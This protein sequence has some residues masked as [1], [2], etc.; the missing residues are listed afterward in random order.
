MTI[1]R[2]GQTIGPVERL[3]HFKRSTALGGLGAAE[4][5]VI[6]EHARERRFRNGEAVLREGEPAAALH[7]VVDG[8]VHVARRG[9]VLGHG[10]PGAVAG[11]FAIFARDPE[12]IEAVAEAETLTLEIDV[13]TLHEIFEDHF[14]VLHHVLRL[15]CSQL[16]DTFAERPGEMQRALSTVRPTE[17]APRELDYVQRIFYL[18]RVPVFARCS[19]NALSEL[20]RGLNEMT[21]EAGTPLWTA[22]EPSGSVLLVVSGLALCT[23]PGGVVFVAGGGSPL[24]AIESVAERPRFFGATA[25]TRLVALQGTVETM[26]DVFEDNFEMAMDYLAGMAHLLLGVHERAALSGTGAAGRVYGCDAEHVG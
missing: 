23:T 21:W 17:Q 20:S 9:R 14:S 5:A 15:V 26:I 12:G 25:E 11:G 10:G 16:V 7:V 24:G 2:T 3:L 19:I 18:R 4:L 6:A 1:A 8:K 22:G 13:D